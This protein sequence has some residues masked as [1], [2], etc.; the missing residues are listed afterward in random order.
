MIFETTY[1]VLPGDRAAVSA[2]QTNYKAQHSR[3]VAHY[4]LYRPD[5][6]ETRALQNYTGSW[7]SPLTKHLIDREVRQHYRKEH[8]AFAEEVE[9][10]HTDLGSFMRRSPEAPEDIHAYSNISE[11]FHERLSQMKDGA[12]FRS[13]AWV[14]SSIRPGTHIHTAIHFHIPAGSKLGA[15]VDHHSVHAGEHEFLISHGSKW[16]LAGREN[17]PAWTKNGAQSS[18]IA[19]L[20]HMEPR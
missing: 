16:K 14:S 5:A 2:A 15:Y 10:I 4:S 19:T 17:A 13:S 9:K 20:Y 3:L 1:H 12:L 8:P 6:D 7:S 11:K 18:H